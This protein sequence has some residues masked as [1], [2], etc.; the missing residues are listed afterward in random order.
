MIIF[1]LKKKLILLL[2]VYML[3]LMIMLL[4]LNALFGIALENYISLMINICL[5]IK[6][7]GMYLMKILLVL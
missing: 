3:G 1:G 2:L 6:A 7:I 4:K 5:Y